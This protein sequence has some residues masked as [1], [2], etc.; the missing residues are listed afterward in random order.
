[1][2]VGAGGL[3]FAR[4]VLFFWALAAAS[5]AGA[6]SS[7]EDALRRVR[8]QRVW[9]DPQWLRLGH[10]KP[11][12]MGRGYAS[13]AE[14]G[15]FFLDPSGAKDPRAEIEAMTRG[16]FDDNPGPRPQHPRCRF[17]ARASWLIGRL[18]VDASLLVRADCSAYE[19][20]RRLMDPGKASL[21]FASAYLSNPASMFGHTF[22]RLERR[23]VGEGERLR[24][25]TLNFSAETGDDGGA[26]F[27]LKG[28]AGLYP[29]RYAVQPYYMMVQQY[30]NIESRDL[31]EYRLSMSTGEI[32]FLV[33][34]AWE[35]GA[36]TF[37]YYFFS[38]NCSYQLLPA[39]EAALPDRSL[40]AGSPLVVAPV[41]T[42]R[43][44]LAQPQ[45]VEGV[46]F[47]PS[48][49]TS[50]R[51]R[52][53]QL[54]SV[55]RRAAEAFAGG[56]VD[57]GD[58]LLSAMGPQRQALVLD[59]AHDYIL[60]KE[61]HSPDVSDTVRILERNI[62]TRR[63]KI[64]APSV[65]VGAPSWAAPPDEAHRRKRVRFGGGIG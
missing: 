57:D 52:R 1:M 8:A 45:L 27:A 23:G 37:P 38:K 53:G 35:M 29:G 63:A 48:H 11:A 19:D 33:A 41:D 39:L 34:H 59:A 51:W 47:R 24:D 36:A 18:D 5:S 31:W 32:D 7:T 9:E 30:N 13:D 64:G 6:L 3:R 16:L 26:L 2:T 21:I 28:L 17:P 44:V 49:A 12:W 22:L 58:A 42:L 46:S 65:E 61:G 54:G 10:W 56:R 20:W 40:M 15:D 4:P 62:L 50:M 43:A 60:Y 14:Q 55:E 25:H